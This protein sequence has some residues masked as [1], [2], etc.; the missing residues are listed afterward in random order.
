MEQHE[1]TPLPACFESSD[2]VQNVP[3]KHPHLMNLQGAGKVEFDLYKPVS[4]QLLS[5]T[6]T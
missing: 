5:I 2:F 6:P 3:I 1:T 4:T